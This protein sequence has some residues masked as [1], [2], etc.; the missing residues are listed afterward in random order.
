MHWISHYLFA[1]ALTASPGALAG[2]ESTPGC[3]TSRPIP[4][5]AANAEQVA[6]AIGVLPLVQRLRS[7]ASECVSAGAPFSIDE[8]TLRQQI[9]ESVLTALLDLHEVLAEIDF[10]R[11]Q[12]LELRDRLS[13]AR[14]RKVN[15]LTL[16]SIIIGT[17]SGVVGNSMQFRNSLAKTGDWIQSVGGAG[18]VALSILALRQPGG[19]GSL[20]I[21]PNMLAPLFGREP[22][23]RAM[24]PQDV[25]TYLNTAPATD[26]R[27][28]VPWTDE[29]I[30]EWT[31]LGR[32]GPPNSP[33]SQQKLNQLASRIADQ[34]PLSINLLT[35]RS[36][37]LADL[38]SRVSLM[39][40][41]L[42]DLMKSISIPPAQ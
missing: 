9:T 19:K 12:I 11:A 23:L 13:G 20:G 25:W 27:V 38:R 10:E 29:L 41:D 24:Y 6:S 40:R 34:R 16:A 31:R 33:E 22:E 7:V 18:S 1:I 17:G 35:D 42:R 37:M 5:L 2:Q 8:L 39:N 3:R 15:V 21:A 26:P 36:T 30:A 4:A 28:H 32:I 14:D